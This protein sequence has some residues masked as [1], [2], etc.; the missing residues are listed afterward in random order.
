M[1]WVKDTTISQAIFIFT[2][3]SEGTTPTDHSQLVSSKNLYWFAFYDFFNI[4]FFLS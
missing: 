3:I 4:Y 1:F 2:F